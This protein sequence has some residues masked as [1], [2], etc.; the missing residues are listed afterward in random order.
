MGDFAMGQW[1]ALAVFVLLV[2]SVGA[3]FW[4]AVPAAMREQAAERREKR[5]AEALAKAQREE[6]GA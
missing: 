1:A 2:A 6:G 3:C 4:L 5:R